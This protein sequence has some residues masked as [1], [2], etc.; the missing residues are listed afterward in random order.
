M[1]SGVFFGYTALI[2]GMIKRIEEELGNPTTR[3]MTGGLAEIFKNSLAQTIQHHE[4]DL[5]LEGL[6]IIYEQNHK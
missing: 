4:S 5:T 1:N 3:I 2:E 6:K